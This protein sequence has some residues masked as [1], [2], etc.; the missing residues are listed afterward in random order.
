MKFLVALIIATTL[1]GVG[2]AAAMHNNSRGSKSPLPD[3]VNSFVFYK[4]DTK[5]I[6]LIGYGNDR[7]VALSCNW[8][9]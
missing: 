7:D 1:T 2:S 8:G 5:C 4:G 3:F 9:H 6:G